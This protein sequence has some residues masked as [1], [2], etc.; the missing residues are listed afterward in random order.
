MC[1]YEG[2]CAAAG[3]RPWVGAPLCL[4]QS[5]VSAQVFN[6][7]ENFRPDLPTSRIQVWEPVIRETIG[8]GLDIRKRDQESKSQTQEWPQVCTGSKRDQSVYAC[9][10]ICVAEGQT[11]SNWTGVAD[12]SLQV[13]AHPGL[14]VSNKEETHGKEAGQSAGQ[15]N[16]WPEKHSHPPIPTHQARAPHPAEP[17]RGG[18]RQVTWQTSMHEVVTVPGHKE[19]ILSLRKPCSLKAGEGGRTWSR[20]GHTRAALT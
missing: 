1:V 2:V 6:S 9:V 19:H 15:C 11:A 10:Y 14:Q 8:Q 4:S 12:T 7:L 5:C 20:G 13:H 16:V 17:G 18:C 3:V